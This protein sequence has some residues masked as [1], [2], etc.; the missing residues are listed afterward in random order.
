MDGGAGGGEGGYGEEAVGVFVLLWGVSY[1]VW[2]IRW[3]NID[4]GGEGIVVWLGRIGVNSFVLVFGGL[5]W[6]VQRIEMESGTHN[7]LFFR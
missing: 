6:G 7:S 5:F 3:C 1:G 4:Y 2:E